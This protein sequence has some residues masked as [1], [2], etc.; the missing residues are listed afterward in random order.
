MKWIISLLVL[1]LVVISF[2]SYR[3]SGLEDRMESIS[4]QTDESPAANPLQPAPAVAKNDQAP[5]GLD[6]SALRRIVRSELIAFSD[7]LAATP[8]DTKPSVDPV[9]NAYRLDAVR[10]ELSYHIEQ[11]EISENDMMNLQAE[12]A[13]LDPDSRTMMLRELVS[14]L[15]SGDLKGRL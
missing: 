10:E 8:E 5:I 11:G 2:Q 13:R 1:Q 15:N 7:S 12:I 9:E 14:A 3:I 6:E 4:Q